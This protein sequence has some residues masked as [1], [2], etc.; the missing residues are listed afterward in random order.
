MKRA[1]DEQGGAAAKKIQVFTSWD[2]RCP[3]CRRKHLFTA[4]HLIP[5]HL[6]DCR[7]GAV[8]EIRPIRQTAAAKFWAVDWSIGQ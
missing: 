6:A 4:S 8:A 2:A 1:A 7:C 5:R 3:F